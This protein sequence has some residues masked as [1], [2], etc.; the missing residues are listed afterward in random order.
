M[1]TTTKKSLNDYTQNERPKEQLKKNV[2]YVQNIH[3]KEYFEKIFGKKAIMT[4]VWDAVHVF[5]YH[6]TK[7]NK[8]VLLLGPLVVTMTPQKIF[9][10]PTR[11]T[12]IKS[13]LDAFVE[14][15]QT[16]ISEKQVAE[17]QQALLDHII[18]GD[19][20]WESNRSQAIFTQNNLNAAI[21]SVSKLLPD[22][23][24]TGIEAIS[25]KDAFYKVYDV[26]E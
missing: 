16:D 2:R 21:N 23:E 19:M 5:L 22:I 10:I 20:P 15:N 24:Y 7:E 6:S 4:N 3:S 18:D 1:T 9:G 12:A 26:K 11:K 8:T 25:L 14:L 13:T 17:A